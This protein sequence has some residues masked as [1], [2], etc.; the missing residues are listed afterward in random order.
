MEF[1]VLQYFLA[2]AREQSFTSAADYLHLSQP[3]LSRQLKDLED[4]LGKQL[5]VRSN[6]GI[7]LTDEGMIL[8]K[9]AEEMVQLMRQTEDEIAKADEQTTGDVYIGA[10]ESE[11]NRV[12]ARAARRVK[13]K[14]PGINFHISSGNFEYVTE[15]LDKGLIDFGMV[16]GETDP[17]QF[18]ALTL[19]EKNRFAVLMREDS[20]LAQ[21]EIISPADLRKQPLIVSVSELREG[22]SG[23]SWISRDP[24][25]LNAAATYTLIFNATL[26]VEEGLGY[27]ICY[28]KLANT[29]GNGLCYRPLT[30]APE[31]PCHIIWK[32]FQM[33]SKPAEKFL[34]CLQEL[35]DA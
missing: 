9:R 10:G 33:L 5:F 30:G 13:E 32:K 24:E 18:N 11:L 34:G 25:K 2:V 29:A 21:K 27:A 22:G 28:E 35:L 15:R 3:T 16:Y 12:L 17:V 19:P 8:R 1:R 14:Y 23:L 6:R 7:T 4:E 20:P 26:L 31:A